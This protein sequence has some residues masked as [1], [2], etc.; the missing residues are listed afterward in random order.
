MSPYVYFEQGDQTLRHIPIDVHGRATRVTSATYTIVDLRYGEESDGRAV[1]SGSATLGSVNT[2]LSAAAG[3]SAADPKRIPIT[4]STGV[5]AGRHYLVADSDG[6]RELVLVLRVDT[7]VVFAAHE[8]QHDYDTGASLQDVEIGATFPS[9][10]AADEGSGLRNGAGP[11]Q[12]TW[13]YTIGDNEYLVPE[14]KWLTR[15]SVQPFITTI[16]VLRAAPTLAAR[17][18]ERATPYDAIL[19][20]TE[21]FWVECRTA[22]KDPSD[23]RT[24]EIARSAVAYRARE[25]LYRWCGTDRD[26][27]LADKQEERWKALVANLLTGQPKVGAV[28]VDRNTDTAPAG[29]DKR[30]EQQHFRRS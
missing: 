26:D 18:R 25:W 20:A 6:L 7:G 14:T 11:Y 16:D 21:D 22:G 5:V 27:A 1:G 2:A 10:E 12:V 9:A 17:L 30:Y 24:N 23:Y 15:S 8:L 29:G 19:A 3:P 13:N 4:S 28:T